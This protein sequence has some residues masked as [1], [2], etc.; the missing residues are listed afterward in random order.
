MTRHKRDEVFQENGYL[1]QGEVSHGLGGWVRADSP[2]YL[3]AKTI[4][5]F[6]WVLL[7]TA[8]DI[9]QA[10]GELD[11]AVKFHPRDPETLARILQSLQ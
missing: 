7:I 9:D 5:S 2:V 8:D 1:F 4:G 3:F 11:C 6:N 10:L